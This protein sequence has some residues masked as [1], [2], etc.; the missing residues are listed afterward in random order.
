MPRP[1]QYK[2]DEVIEKAVKVFWNKGYASTSV[3]E[4][5]QEMGINQFSMYASFGSK[6]GVFLR[7]LSKYKAKVKEIFLSDLIQSEGHLADIRTFLES[8]VHSVKSGRTPNGCLMANTAMAMGGGDLEVKVQL[9]Q[10]FDLLK[11]VF[12]DV[13]KGAQRNKELA[14]NANID[15][16]ANYLLGCTEGL[17]VTAKVLDDEQL[18]DFIDV[19]MK[20]LR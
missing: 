7:A 15:S 13:L 9:R 6:R 16:Y 11:E 1:K 3:R 10:F 2:E 5:E 8:F 14:V 19:T 4:L 20:S 17:A 12:V 18:D